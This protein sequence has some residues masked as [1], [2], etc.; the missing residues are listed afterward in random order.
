MKYGVGSWSKII[1]SGCL[2]GKSRA[3]LNLQTQRLLGQQS[4]GGKF[5]IFEFE[6]ARHLSCPHIIEILHSLLIFM[7]YFI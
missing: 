6:K 3:Q 5:P 2:P 4:L 7:I 1:E